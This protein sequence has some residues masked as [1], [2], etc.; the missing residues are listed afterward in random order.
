[1]FQPY[2]GMALGQ[3]L[4]MTW[5]L[6]GDREKMKKVIANAMKLDRSWT[7]SAKKYVEAYKKALAK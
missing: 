4:E 7:V 1:M 6:Y 2:T 3:Q 5:E